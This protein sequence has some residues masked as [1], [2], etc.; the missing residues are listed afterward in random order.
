ML[1]DAISLAAI[2]VATTLP[3][4]TIGC[5]IALLHKGPLYIIS[6]EGILDC[7]Y[8]FVPWSETKGISKSFYQPERIVEIKLKNPK[9]HFN[10]TWRSFWGIRQ[11]NLAP[12][13]MRSEYHEPHILVEKALSM[14]NNS[15]IFSYC[16]PYR[17]IYKLILM[18]IGVML[19]CEA[20]YF[21]YLMLREPHTT[22]LTIVLLSMTSFLLLG[23]LT[24]FY[25]LYL[26]CTTNPTLKLGA[27]ALEID[28]IFFLK[29]ITIII[30][31]DQMSSIHP[32][33]TSKDDGLAGIVIC[34]TQENKT[35][36]LFI[37]HRWL[38]ANALDN[39]MITLIKMHK[40]AN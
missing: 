34:Y 38:P 22:T 6:S 5:I 29:C 1:Y 25:R 12:H 8:G 4:I 31:Y 10:G 13:T 40:E 20:A 9:K 24:V 19:S 3:A 37:S 21:S 15:V 39:I 30:P 28:Y 2:V 32:V 35:K 27:T 11:L 26:E 23:S 33:P 36:L 7:R 14:N 17:T 18:T 16:F